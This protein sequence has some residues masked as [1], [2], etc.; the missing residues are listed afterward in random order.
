VPQQNLPASTHYVDLIRL[1]LSALFLGSIISG[2]TATYRDI[3]AGSRLQVDGA[4]ASVT[5]RQEVSVT[6]LAQE[7]EP[8]LDY[9]IGAGDVLYININGKQEFMVLPNSGASK[10]QGSRVDGS[11]KV[12]IPLAGQVKVGGLTLAEAQEKVRDALKPFLKEPWV[13]IEVADYK[14]Q[15]LYLIGSFKTP[16]TYYFD[17][18]MNLLQGISLG[19]GFDANANLRGARLRRDGRIQPVDIYALLTGGDQRQNVWL[20]P[21]DAIYLPDRLLQQVFVFGSVRKPG[22]VQMLNG[23]LN[24]AQAIASAELRETGYDYGHVR[25]IRSLSPTRGELIVVDFDRMMRGRALPFNLQEGDIVYVPRS[26]LGSWNDVIADILPSLQTISA[27][28]QPFV[29]IKYLNGG[30]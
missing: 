27:I 12:S 19:G 5:E 4:E 25:I 16:G 15:S 11:G 1:L 22:P 28:L 8:D 30:N 23:Q 10:I 2:C 17:R 6:P 29:S 24:L 7:S 3:P 9:R 20:K 18:P 13:V 21:G 14:S 26:P